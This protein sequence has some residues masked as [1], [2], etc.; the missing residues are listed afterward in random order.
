M[1]I[2]IVLKESEVSILFKVSTSGRL[3]RLIKNQRVYC[4]DGISGT[5]E[6][7]VSLETCVSCP[8]QECVTWKVVGCD[9]NGRPIRKMNTHPSEVK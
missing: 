9:E 3:D 1:Y 6:Y 7:A 2:T 4:D 8:V 5:E